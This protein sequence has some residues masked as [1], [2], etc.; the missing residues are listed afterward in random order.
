MTAERV[1]DPD[2][3]R[4]GAVRTRLEN[5]AESRDLQLQ[6]ID[7]ADLERNA[8]E[9][10]H[11]IR[12]KKWKSNKEK[13]WK[14]NKEK[15]WSRSIEGRCVDFLRHRCSAYDEIV[16]SLNRPSEWVENESDGHILHVERPNLRAIVKRRILD[17]I[18]EAYPWLKTECERQKQRDGLEE[19][20]GEY[21]IPFA[22]YKG[23]PLRD[24]DVDYL[25]RLLGQGFV[26]RS[27]RTRIVRVLRLRFSAM[28][29]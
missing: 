17:E 7:R 24:L 25:I 18:G 13:E 29:K 5:L 10:Y 23:T 26:Q 3:G 11:A 12:R 15:E 27:L 16:R 28:V 21:V 6:R 8:A 19:N 20:S 9:A 1:C 4:Y 22:P 14:S 2:R